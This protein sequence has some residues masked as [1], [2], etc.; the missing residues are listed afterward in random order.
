MANSKKYSNEGNRTDISRYRLKTIPGQ[1]G[2]QGKSIGEWYFMHLKQLPLWETMLI[3]HPQTHPQAVAMVNYAGGN[4]LRR[5]KTVKSE[6]GV[7]AVWRF[8]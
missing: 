6:E 8:E 1:D 5:F 3:R 2:R 4:L 7:I